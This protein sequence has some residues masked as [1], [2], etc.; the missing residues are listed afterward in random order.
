N[1]SSPSRQRAWLRRTV[2]LITHIRAATLESRYRYEYPSHPK[3]TR[4]TPHVNRTAACTHPVFRL[5][6]RVGPNSGPV[7]D[8]L[9]TRPAAGRQKTLASTA[10]DWQV[11]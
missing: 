5:V 8:K 10:P 1:G 3:V 7:C 9:P 6:T 4:A 11:R 2:S